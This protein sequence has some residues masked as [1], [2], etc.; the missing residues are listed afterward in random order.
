MTDR[1]APYFIHLAL[2]QAR[3]RQSRRRTTLASSPSLAPRLA[4]ATPIDYRQE[5]AFTAEPLSTAR[6]AAL[7]SAHRP[8]QNGTR[9]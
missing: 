5:S 6:P 7:C 4:T 2:T 9:A 8:R 3:P 1:H